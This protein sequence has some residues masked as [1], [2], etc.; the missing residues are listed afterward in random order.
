LFPRVLRL[1]KPVTAG[2]I[3]AL[4]V[5]CCPSARAQGKSDRTAVLSTLE[6]LKRDPKARYVAARAI[7][8]AERALGRADAAKQAGDTSR[9]QLLEALARKWAESASDL[10]RAYQAE[11]RA[12]AVERRLLG[13]Q[14]RLLRAR[15]LLE[16]A[17]A[18][19]ERAR[20]A[21]EKLEREHGD[22]SG[23]EATP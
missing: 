20:A 21:L 10:A 16:E 4:T 13:T 19:V 5:F 11:N 12:T 8:E 14:E 17:M 6:R 9:P 15:A 18:R 7:S 23:K 1:A 2:L 22:P 3:V